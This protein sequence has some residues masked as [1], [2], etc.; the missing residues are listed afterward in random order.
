MSRFRQ[1]ISFL[2][3]ISSLICCAKTSSM[4]IPLPIL[5]KISL[6]P[7]LTLFFI[8]NIHRKD[9]LYFLFFLYFK[10]KNPIL[11]LPNNPKIALIYAYFLESVITKFHYTSHSMRIFRFLC[12]IRNILLISP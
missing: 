5:K 12:F 6:S 1:K 11:L 7:S 2:E 10:S 3:G 9:F 8:P 4:I